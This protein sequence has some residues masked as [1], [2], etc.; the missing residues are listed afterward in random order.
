M[1]FVAMPGA[2]VDNFDFFDRIFL[3]K[4]Q[5]R[6]GHPFGNAAINRGLILRDCAHRGFHAKK[7]GFC[8]SHPRLSLGT[9]V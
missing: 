5:S 2:S 9:L 6:R 8:R 1:S 4:A 7:W 3:T